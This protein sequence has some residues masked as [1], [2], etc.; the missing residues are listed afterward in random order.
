[1]NRAVRLGL[2]GLVAF[3]LA[4][5][6]QVPAAW[7]VHW[8]RDRI[9]DNVTLSGIEGTLWHP[10][11]NRIAVG[12]PGGGLLQAGPAELRVRP[13]GLL[14]GKLET[15]FEAEA[16][17]GQAAGRATVGLGGQWRVPEARASLALE[18][19]GVIDPRLNFG[20][21][22]RLEVTVDGLG[23]SRL[24][25][26]GRVATVIH[27]FRFPGLGPDGVYGTYRARGE[28]AQGGQLKGE[29]S[30]EKARVLAIKGNFQ[31]SLRGGRARFDGE[32]RAPKGAPAEA[33]QLLSLFRNYQNGRAR[34]RWR[35]RLR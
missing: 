2:L 6:A 24:P 18:R 21:Q 32:A 20:Q 33:E 23:G 5:V 16:L 22:G 9:P 13:L 34:I 30:T 25:D 19:L 7:L 1:M 4:L 28:F 26:Q 31:A 27:D 17:G 3:G 35:G 14:G 11:V 12:L 29:I 15:A 8:N 10:R